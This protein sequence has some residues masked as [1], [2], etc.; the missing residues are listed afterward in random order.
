MPQDRAHRGPP[1]VP[2]FRARRRVPV[3]GVAGARAARSNRARRTL[4]TEAALGVLA[5]AGMRGLT[6]RAVAAGLPAGTT[7]AYVRTR[8]ALL[9]ALVRRLVELDRAEPTAAAERAPVL[10]TADDLVEG[11]AALVAARTR[12]DGRRRSP[13][14][15]ACALESV[16]DPGP[17]DILVP[18]E[19]PG[20][21]AVRAFLAARGAADPEARTLSLLA[22]V[23]G[24]VLDRVV[25]GEE[26]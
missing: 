9:G 2:G 15:C 25:A 11:L 12:G 6:H 21:E 7:S 17:R 24:L 4:L 23:D 26:A 22:C 10:R 3:R 5:D 16:R 8:S 1:A 18:R 14:R 20:R 13:A 19:N